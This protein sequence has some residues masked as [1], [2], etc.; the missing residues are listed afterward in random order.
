MAGVLVTHP[1]GEHAV[2][3][4]TG[5]VGRSLSLARW[6]RSA[7]VSAT[8]V[9]PAARTVLFAGVADPAGLAATLADWPGDPLDS[10]E[11]E[12]TVPV[13]Y[14]GADLDFAA[15]RWGM[16]RAEAIATHAGLAF[17][18]AFC[19]FAP[20]FAYLTGL[21]VEL[22]LPRLE[23][24]RTRVPAGSVAVA[25]HWTGVYPSASPGGWRLL[26]HTPMTLF[27]PDLPAPALLAPGTR[28]RLTVV[29]TSGEQVR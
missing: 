4:E 18:V 23:T 3:A 11:H 9:V 8:E 2:L 16:T 28:V 19:G 20:G 26:G 17:V 21:P 25:D 7:G 10:T 24:P 5:D 13:A 22:A 27:D 14:D 12:V 1:V 29:E 15:R 6:A